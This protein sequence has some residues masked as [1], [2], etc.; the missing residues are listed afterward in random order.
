MLE[1]SFLGGTHFV[2]GSGFAGC[3]RFNGLSSRETRPQ[4]LRLVIS[5]AE[6]PIQNHVNGYTEQRS[7]GTKTSGRAVPAPGASGSNLLRISCRRSL[8]TTPSSTTIDM[9]LKPVHPN[10][11]PEP[12]EEPAAEAFALPSPLVV[13]VKLRPLPGLG[14]SRLLIW[15]Y[16]GIRRKGRV[17]H[18]QIPFPILSSR[19]F[20]SPN[21]SRLSADGA[22]E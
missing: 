12:A 22:C 21:S 2:T 15:V 5:A 20:Y 7:F 1:C 19:M 11:H 10:L 3:V 8:S 18:G 17:Q 13:L 4:I 6:S 14:F 16:L 9:A